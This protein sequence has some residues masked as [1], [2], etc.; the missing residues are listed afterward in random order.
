MV[1]F[2]NS[3]VK[4]PRVEYV[5][6]VLSYLRDGRERE[7]FEIALAQAQEAKISTHS[8]NEDAF[9]GLKMA[10]EN[11]N[12]SPYLSRLAFLITD[13]GAIRNDDSFSSSGMNET[14]IADMA[15]AKGV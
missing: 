15:M 4:T 10:L 7:Q 8:F 12:W 1:A 3:T 6:R 11:L 14:E 13:A 9:A 5:S 2:R